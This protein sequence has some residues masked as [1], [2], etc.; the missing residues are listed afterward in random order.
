MKFLNPNGNARLQAI[1]S[2][3]NFSLPSS[4]H[5]PPTSPL[6]PSSS[7]NTSSRAGSPYAQSFSSLG[8]D[9]EAAVADSHARTITLHGTESAFFKA[10]L[11]YLYTASTDIG[12]VFTFLFEDDSFA[13]SKEEALDRLSQV[14]HLF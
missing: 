1:M 11:D 14:S 9:K 10:L 12:E 3:S 7:S 13:L 8:H 2:G 4:L 5:P 6:T